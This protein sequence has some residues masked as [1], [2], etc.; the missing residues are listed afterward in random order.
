M[1]RFR[2]RPLYLTYLAHQEM[3]RVL[4][5]RIGP[6]GLTTTDCLVL[7]AAQEEPGLSGVEL[8]AVCGVTKQALAQ[9][10]DKLE[11]R[12][13][14]VRKRTPGMGRLLR[15]YLT[16]EGEILARQVTELVDELQA[17]ALTHVS[18]P[19]GARI[20]DLLR[21]NLSAWQKVLLDQIDSKSNT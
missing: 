8:A 11:K 20:G 15:A 14:L 9:I 12:G 5:E 3:K 6:W 17:E 18:G 2:E 7:E 16:D 10:L 21:A 1:S 13:A 19:D 4:S